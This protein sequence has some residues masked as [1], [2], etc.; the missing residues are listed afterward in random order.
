MIEWE[1][2]ECFHRLFC[3]HS[4]FVGNKAEVRKWKRVDISFI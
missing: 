1:S 4:F 2:D 3:E